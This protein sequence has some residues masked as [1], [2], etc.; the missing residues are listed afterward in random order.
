MK[1]KIGIILL[2]FYFIFTHGIL[3][4]K[5]LTAHELKQRDFDMAGYFSLV[6]YL[7]A[8]DLDGII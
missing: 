7:L 1:I 5:N 4:G 2:I 3:E 6:P 8:I